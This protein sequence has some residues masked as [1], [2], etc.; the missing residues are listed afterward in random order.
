MLLVRPYFVTLC[1][2]ALAGLGLAVLGRLAAEGPV[3]SEWKFDT[4]HLTNGRTVQGLLLEES[5]A[6][7]RF[8]YVRR[9]PG[10]ATVAIVT[11]FQRPEVARVQKLSPADRAALER[12]LRDLDPNQR[13]ERV[14][15]DKLELRPVSWGKEERGGSAYTSHHFTLVSNARPDIIRRAALRLEEI[16]A[17]YARFVPPRH[18]AGA[19]TRIVLVRSLAEYQA[20]LRTRGKVIQNPA[21]FDPAA[22]E[23]VCASDLQR[24]DDL[25]E[26]AR[27]QHDEQLERIGKLEAE[28]KKLSKGP[29]RDRLSKQ[30]FE[31]RQAIRRANQN[32]DALFRTATDRLFQMLS[33]EAF[34]AYLNTFVYRE[35][36]AEVP[37]WLNEGLAQIFE[38]ALIE[39][40]ELRVGHADKDRLERIKAAVRQKEML[41]LADLLRAGPRQFLV[42]HATDGQ[43]SDRYYLTAWGVA[44][45]LTFE[46]RLLGTPRMDQFVRSLKSGEDVL[47]TF[48]DLVGQPLPEFE[49]RFHQYLLNLHAD[50]TTAK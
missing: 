25:L 20:L 39:A 21:Y 29:V 37:R 28:I 14:R 2:L 49:K 36:E 22:N 50:G 6:T 15:L 34:H 41:P 8:Q 26:D 13:G 23:V 3:R 16:Y 7:I 1:S 35:A 42:A 19:P 27:R 4:L 33:H 48:R 31:G 38:T 30:A 24:L 46:H 43:I 9:N 32:N 11:T 47:D 17:A 45:Y 5:A 12:R 44:F 10:V 40:G 18:A